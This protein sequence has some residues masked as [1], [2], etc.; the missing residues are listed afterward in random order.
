MSSLPNMAYIK[1]LDPHL[2]I[3]ILEFLQKNNSSNEDIKN[4][5]IKILSSIQDFEKQKLNNIFDEAKIKELKEE[6]EK[7]KKELSEKLEGFLNLSNNCIRENNYDLNSFSLGR[8]IIDETS[9]NLIILYAKKL[10]NSLEFDKAR[11]LLTS[12]IKLNKFVNK[13]LSKIIYALYLLYSI[14][15]LTKQEGKIIEKNFIEILNSLEHLKD[16]LDTEFKKTNFDSVD[17]I[18]IDFKEIVLYRGYIIHWSL[19]LLENNMELFLD[20]LFKDTYFTIIENV[21]KY[22][23]PYLIIFSILTKSKRYINQIKE[24]IKKINIQGDKF[25]DLFKEI[26]INYD[27]GKSVKLFEE[28]KEIMK[29]D[30]F[31]YNYIDKFNAKFKEII[32]ENYIFLNQ[33]IDLNELS[34]L[35]N[36][37]IDE[38]RKYTQDI[39]KFNYPLAK[40]EEKGNNEIE[41]VNDEQEM[42]NYYNIKT[43]ELF[44]LTSNMV[45]I[46]KK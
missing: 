23:Y 25:I 14:N 24:S 10:Y 34:K 41:I 11:N 8:K 46:M 40:I 7:E 15:V 38:T 33:T 35:F 30:Y 17:K 31:V 9:P 45:K 42:E 26:F 2:V 12:F 44:D 22:M 28:C 37:N 27:I 32:I 3:Q 39:I 29:N 4:L 43:Q 6:N 36:D 19:F 13:N 5:Y 16:Y 20:T 1:Y 21:F 18:Q